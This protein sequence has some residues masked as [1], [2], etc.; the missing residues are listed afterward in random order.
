MKVDMK[1]CENNWVCPCNVFDADGNEVGAHPRAV[2]SCDTITGSCIVS[3][4][5]GKQFELNEH[6]QAKAPLSIRFIGPDLGRFNKLAV[7]L[8]AEKGFYGD[9]SN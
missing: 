2:V 8:A 3:K 9:S 4:E 5:G 1:T 6:V 7:A